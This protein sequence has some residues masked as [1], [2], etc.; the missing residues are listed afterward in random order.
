MIL[1]G[2][3]ALNQFPKT[4]KFV[5]ANKIRETMYSI[6][7]LSIILEKKYYKKTTL[8]ELD[9][10]LDIL[11]NLIRIAA[12]KKLYPNQSPCL[13]IK[14]YEHWAKL[15]N[16]IGKMIGGYIKSIRE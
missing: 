6:L 11:R 10:Q 9:V 2:N 13:S 15:I 7:E 1:Y 8:K 4:E 5:L 12:D 14:K 16:E 3:P